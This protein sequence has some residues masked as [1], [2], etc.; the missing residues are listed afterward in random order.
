MK[1]SL[2]IPAYNEEKYISKALTAISEMTLQPDEVIVVDNNSTDKTAAIVKKFPWVTLIS[3]T[4]KQGT[5]AARQAGFE[6]STGDIVALLDADC[7]PHRTWFED[8]VRAVRSKK[9]AA[10]TGPY[11]FFDESLF[12]RAIRTPRK[13]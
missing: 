11:D 9:V 13:L 8:G 1:T 4:E 10:V 6:A 12:L 5:N 2:I 3:Y 7:I